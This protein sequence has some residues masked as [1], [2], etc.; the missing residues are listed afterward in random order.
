[1][2]DAKRRSIIAKSLQKLRLYRKEHGLCRECGNPSSGRTRCTWCRRKHAEREGELV[3]KREPLKV[4]PDGREVLN[5]KTAAGATEYRNRKDQMFSRQKATCPLCDCVF[6]WS[7]PSTFDHQNGRGMGGSI[8]D[9]RI[10]I[11]G[12]WFN[13]AL[14]VPCQSLKGS[15]RYHWVKEGVQMKYVPQ[16]PNPA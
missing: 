1:M 9:D 4:Y 7:N 10:E 15:R 3:I 14:C 11:D 5:T 6:T 16:T 8:R 13:A 12:Q 2:T